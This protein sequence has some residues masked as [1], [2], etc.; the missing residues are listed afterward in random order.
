MELTELTPLELRIVS[1]LKQVGIL[2]NKEI[3]AK[4]NKDPGNISRKMKQLVEKQVVKKERKSDGK[5]TSNYYSLNNDIENLQQV[6]QGET[7]CKKKVSIPSENIYDAENINVR[8]SFIPESKRGTLEIS[9]YHPRQVQSEKTQMAL[10]VDRTITHV[11]KY[12]SFVSKSRL[13]TSK[14]QRLVRILSENTKNYTW[15]FD[16]ITLFLVIAKKAE[17]GED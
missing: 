9:E 12:L 17:I 7:S 3:A 1:E 15:I 6:V 8:E 16:C 4:L 11:L 5:I 2:T 13:L 14:E 10:D